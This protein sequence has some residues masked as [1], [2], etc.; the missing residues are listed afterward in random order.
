MDSKM[1]SMMDSIVGTYR[2]G[3]GTHSPLPGHDAPHDGPH[4]QGDH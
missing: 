3:S 1:D 4:E 2:M